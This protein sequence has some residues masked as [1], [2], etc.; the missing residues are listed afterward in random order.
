MNKREIETDIF[1]ETHTRESETKAFLEMCRLA[2]LAYFS[3]WMTEE[4][5]Q[6]EAL[7]H[8]KRYFDE[9]R[10]DDKKHGFPSPLTMR[11]EIMRGLLQS[12]ASMTQKNAAREWLIETKTYI[13]YYDKKPVEADITPN[14]WH[15]F[16]RPLDRTP[17]LIARGTADGIAAEYETAV[18]LTGW[19][20]CR[21]NGYHE[22]TVLRIPDAWQYID[23][24]IPDELRG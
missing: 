19:G 9:F 11:A 4:Q 2:S 6:A 8:Y 22:I 5:K 13:C 10:R 3:P 7:K 1:L 18:Y 20:F 17:V 23:Q 24:N 16:K 14:V 15:A 12:N 21:V